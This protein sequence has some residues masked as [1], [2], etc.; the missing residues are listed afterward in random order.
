MCALNSYQETFPEQI[1][2]TQVLTRYDQAI[3]P[4]NASEL[5]SGTNIYIQDLCPLNRIDH[6]GLAIHDSIA[7]LVAMD[8]IKHDGSASL[9]RIKQTSCVNQ[10]CCNQPY[11]DLFNQ[12]TVSS[13]INDAF[14]LNS[15]IENYPKLT[16]EPKLK[17]HAIKQCAMKY[18]SSSISH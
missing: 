12:S 3:C 14:G 13:V 4:I 5:N 10:S 16:E 8:A 6:L 11:I 15:F 17:C 7:F 2:Y 9:T 1:A 18:N